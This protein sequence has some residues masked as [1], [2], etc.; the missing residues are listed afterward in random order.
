[1][2]K[3]GS[4]NLI[5]LGGGF[6][7]LLLYVVLIEVPAEKREESEKVKRLFA[8]ISV[9][10]VTAVEL[11]NAD[12]FRIEREAEGWFVTSP[13]RHKTDP[14][15][16]ANFF[17]E[18][19]ATETLR[20]LTP[21]T[22][23]NLAQYGL[24]APTNWLVIS[25][26]TTNL[27]LLIGKDFA[28][29]SGGEEQDRQVINYL[30]FAGDPLIYTVEYHKVAPLQRR[31]EYFRFRNYFMFDRGS[32]ASFTVNYQGQSI[33]LDRS[34]EQWYLAGKPPR[35]ADNSKVSQFLGNFYNFQVDGFLTDEGNPAAWGINWNRNSLVIRDGEG[36]TRTLAF[37]KEVAARLACAVSDDPGIFEVEK[38]K[39]E[40]LAKSG[41]DFLP[42]PPGE[43]N[44]AADGGI[45]DG[46]VD[47]TVGG[48]RP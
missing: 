16:M 47:V 1:M 2:A 11:G 13:K 32:L 29:E 7:L 25:T 24:A 9:D 4:R 35:E 5:L 38:F 14:A 6:L 41:T 42:D 17:N 18:V 19:L 27:R 3:R 33:T 43:T 31:L 26:K 48:G 39:F 15:A 21:R 20:V 22:N 40:R 37:G 44:A 10:D 23:A 46:G 45:P 36:K 12:R 8:G 28:I 30:S 34:N